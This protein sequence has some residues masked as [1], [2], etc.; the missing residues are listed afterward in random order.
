MRQTLKLLMAL[1]L[2]ALL[3]SCASQYYHRGYSCNE[4]HSGG[5][6][7]PSHSRNGWSLNR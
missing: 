5:F 6:C 1:L 4:A 3:A 7:N 2:I